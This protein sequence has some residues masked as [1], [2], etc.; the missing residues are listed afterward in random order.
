[1]KKLLLLLLILLGSNSLVLASSE[2][3][4]DSIV[5]K[6]ADGTNYSKY[7]YKYDSSGKQT[8]NE[9]YRWDENKSDWIG[10]MKYVWK[11]GSNGKHT[12]EE[13]YIWDTDKNNW[14]GYSKSVY[15]YDKKGNVSLYESY[16]WDKVNWE[17]VLEFITTYYFSGLSSINTES[18]TDF[19]IHFGKDRF[20]V[21]GLSNNLGKLQLSD[22]SGRIL[23]NATVTSNS[24]ISTSDLPDGVYVVR[25]ES[26]KNVMETKFMKP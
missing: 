7:V 20:T 6:Y 22:L 8:F 4:L 14:R 26:G 24:F 23:K 12:L 18:V 13:S 3:Q 10:N 11:Y 19:N 2:N 17:W 1:M 15:E 16:E 5:T 21:S 25:I 9:S